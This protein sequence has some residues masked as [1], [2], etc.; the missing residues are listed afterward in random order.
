VTQLIAPAPIRKTLLVRTTRQRAFSV[1]TDGFDR[2]WPR[3]HTIGAPLTRVILEPFEG[4]RWYSQ[5]EDGVD[6][7]WGEV[8]AW[9]PPGRL[10]LAWRINQDFAY[11]PDLLTEVEVRFSETEDGATRVDFEHRGLEGFGARDAA[12]KTRDLMD[13]GWGLILTGFHQLAEAEAS[14]C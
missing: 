13:E 14:A 12:G 2:W 8:L 4:G 7:T 5:H 11:D 10:V 1:F 9:E 6:R 3:S